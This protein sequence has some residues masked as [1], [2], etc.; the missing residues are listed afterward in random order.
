MQV[1]KGVVYEPDSS[2][3]MLFCLQRMPLNADSIKDNKG[4]QKHA[5]S[6]VSH[7]TR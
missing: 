7:S 1:T 6:G 2:M 3:S 5:Y 4:I